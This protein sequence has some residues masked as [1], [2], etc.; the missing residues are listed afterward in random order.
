MDLSRFSPKAVSSV[1]SDAKNR[2]VDYE[3]FSSRATDYFEKQA[4]KIYSSYQDK[5]YKASALDFDDLLVYMV[6]ILKLFPQVKEKYQDKFQYILVDE[7]QDTNRAQNQIILLL[8]ERHKRLCV[9]GDDDQ[10]IY[11]WRGAEIK[12]IIEFD[13]QFSHTEVI[14]LEQNHRLTQ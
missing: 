1:I 3:T 8:S 9:V 6:D 11:S 10:S 2:L 7:F 4:A 12:N 14:K 5:L 13:R